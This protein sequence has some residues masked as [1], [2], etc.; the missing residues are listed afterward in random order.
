MSRFKVPVRGE[1]SEANQQLFDQL[2]K[3]IGMVPNL[4]ATMAHSET[5]LAN[6]LQFQQGKTLFSNREKEVVNLVVSEVNAC[7]Y[8]QSAHTAVAKMNGFSEEEI[9]QI[10]AGVSEWNPKIDALAKLT[11]AIAE[12]KGQNV[13]EELEVFFQNG[14][15]KA[16]L[17]DLVLL[18]A[19]KVVM[20]YLHNIT[21]IPIDFPIAPS[22]EYIN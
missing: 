3:A 6:Y 2:Q 22:L 4:Y 11:K 9:F 17:V 7:R 13:Q 10:R 16:H 12:S 18:I 20:N 14:F 1:V 5:A 8:C 19:D 21:Q 15:T